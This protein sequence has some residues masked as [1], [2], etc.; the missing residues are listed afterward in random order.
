M[1]TVTAKLEVEF[2]A[3]SG[4]Y[5]DI[6][7]RVRR[8]SI[9]RPR[10]TIQGGA[11]TTT[12]TA[13]LFNDPV[14][15][16]CQLSPDNPLSPYFPDVGRDRRVRLTA[17]WN[18]GANTSVRFFGWSDQWIP[19]A[20]ANPPETAMVTLTASC[21]LSRYARRALLSYFGQRVLN[22]DPAAL[23]YPF[24]EIADSDN[25]RVVSG[26]MAG[27]NDGEVVAPAGYPGS[28]TFTTPDG[29]H[30]TDGQI[31]FTRGDDNT[32][33]P[34]VLIKM[35]SLAAF[36]SGPTYYSGWFK[37]AADPKGSTGDDMLGAYDVNGDL[38]WT[39]SV[40]VS[41][42]LVTWALVD[43]T[44]VSKSFFTTG[45]PR[46]EGWH[47]W[48][49]FPVSATST[50]M[51]TRT[52]GETGQQAFGSF[53]WSYDPRA[54]Q[55]ITVGG[56]MPPFR[57]GRN[58]NT[59]LGSIS[60]L[61]FEYGSP[62]D[63]AESGNPGI[64]RTASQVRV[65]AD[66]DT[67]SIDALV[68]GSVS[69][70]TDST[71][72]QFR[73]GSANILDRQN[74]I[75]RSS[76]GAVIT[77]P[78]GRRQFLRAGELRLSIPALI[79]NAE[80]DLSAPDGGW[81]G[82]KD[83]KPTRVTVG[84]PAG[85]IEV[86]DTATEAATG[87]RLEGGTIDTIAGTLSVA[88]SVA[89]QIL[90]PSGGRISAFGVDVTTTSTDRVTSVMSLRPLQRIR[91][92]TL[93]TALMGVSWVD[94]YLNGW[95]EAHDP[96]D[97][98]YRFQFDSDPA[99]DPPE[100]VF[101]DA[102]YGRFGLTSTTVTGGTCVGNTGTGTVIITSAIGVLTT[103]GAMYPMDLDWN[104]ERITVSGVGGGTSPQTVTVTA[105]GVAPSVARVHATG[106]MI[107]VHFPLTFGA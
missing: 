38:L 72:L 35:R 104:G 22:Y 11:S 80:Q 92:D 77:R 42:T 67:A 52:K 28:A 107:D 70:G 75:A 58:T 7:S 30:L 34:V 24:N 87:L 18:A 8:V 55:Y 19:D 3:G 69:S 27:A 36:P 64:V 95:T 62:A 61:A 97:G 12:L 88:Q 102:D 68:G 2:V 13:E 33:A 53:A 79:F 25:A 81:Q 6:S 51:F 20:G 54:V 50:Q 66:Q 84:S 91:I 105:R 15:G 71:P 31:D 43:N 100:G 98:S 21:V 63:L 41:A 101:D 29:G 37:L 1:P 40:R 73:T 90:A 103:N 14:A 46:D 93:P 32:P 99:D 9:S 4:T 56:K 49:L 10:Y 48:A 76:G 86:V 96:E 44:G 106:E 94:L 57:R 74:E 59:F 23:Y 65:L 47:Y 45:A 5:V 17:V 39:F 89:G 83:E 78:D 85:T 16:V 60:S 82:V 26:T